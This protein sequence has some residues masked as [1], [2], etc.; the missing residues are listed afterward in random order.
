MNSKVSLERFIKPKPKIKAKPKPKPQPERE[1]RV[2]K[3]AFLCESCPK[4]FTRASTLTEHI[5]T[6]TGERP[7]VCRF[8]SQTFVREKDCRRHEAIHSV[9]KGF[10]C[11]GTLKN[12][13]QWG[14]GRGFTRADALA[15]HFS[16]A[17]GKNCLQPLFAEDNAERAQG[18]V[19]LGQGPTASA[20]YNTQ[21]SPSAVYL[22][23]PP[24]DRSGGNIYTLPTALFSQ[25]PEFEDLDWSDL[26]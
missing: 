26:R 16:S 24:N 7:F 4:Q 14:C 23:K 18:Q 17:L 8:C 19:L 13:T 20:D 11:S 6:H 22:S 15:R 1:P 3:V 21:E 9:K 2:R 12:N 10:T 25:F 5:R